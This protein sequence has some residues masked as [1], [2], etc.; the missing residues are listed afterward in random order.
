MSYVQKLRKQNLINP[1]KWLP[2]S[3][4]YE[5]IM[6]SAA[7]G[8]SDVGS[9]ID[10]YGFCIPHKN[11]IFPHL[12]GE[13][14]GFGRQTNRFDQWQEH[15]ISSIDGKKEFDFSMYNI[16]KYFSLCMENNPNMIDS[17]FTPQ[18]CITHCTAIGNMVREN[19]KIF[20][21]KGAWFKFKGY[22]YSQM[23]KMRNKNP[24]G[25]RKERVKQEGYDLKFAYHTVR[26]LNEIEQILM[27]GDLDLQRNREQLKSI[28]RGEWRLGDIESY[29]NSKEKE[30]ET[31]YTNSKLQ[32]SPDEGKI[33]QLLLS[34]LEEY[35][36]NL[37]NC[38]VNVDK[39]AQ[40]LQDIQII[41]NGLK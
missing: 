6:G 23:H 1:P 18:T 36:G 15:H 39:A 13:I 8:V 40:A 14:P 19:R 37:N 30:L 10:I 12:R 38:I 2:N 21:H 22:S 3:V 41:L 16:V 7:Y 34:C 35:Y 31:L 9:D 29:F 28:R 33:K 32:H 17:L 25:K 26:L 20:L 27:E 24:I 5:T 11:D 4:Q